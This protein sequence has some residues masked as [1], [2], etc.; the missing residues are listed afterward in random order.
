MRFYCDICSQQFCSQKSLMEH[1]QILHDNFDNKLVKIKCDQC[2]SELLS[3]N[4]LKR[5]IKQYHSKIT[6]SKCEHCDKKFRNTTVLGVHIQNVHREKI[7]N[8]EFCNLIFATISGLKYHKATHLED[9]KKCNVC[10]KEIRE[11]SMNTHIEIH[12][13]AKKVKCHICNNVLC[14]KN[15]LSDHIIR[16]HK[17]LKKFACHICNQIFDL[18]EHLKTHLKKHKANK[19]I[20]SCQFCILTFKSKEKLG[21]HCQYYHPKILYKCDICENDF[22]QPSTLKK[23]FDMVH[24]RTTTTCNICGIELRTICLKKHQVTIH[25]NSKTQLQCKICPKTFLTIGY[26]K[27]HTSTVHDRSLKC[28]YCNKMFGIYTLKNILK[29]YMR[30]ILLSLVQH[31]IKHLPRI[32]NLIDISNLYMTRSE[33]INAM[34]VTKH[35]LAVKL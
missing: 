29:T 18:E 20:F 7:F 4:R 19:V 16:A 21:K 28:N 6:N 9:L 34:H 26:L 25:E 35:F 14:D 3:S 12:N 31:V 27:K 32:T 10:G 30:K 33:T 13:Q 11:T 24:E 23:H 15:Y 8:C 5:H 1:V 22:L 17:R 2:S